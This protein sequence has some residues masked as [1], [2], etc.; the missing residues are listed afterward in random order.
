MKLIYIALFLGLTGLYFVNAALKIDI[1]NWENLIHSGIR[2][3][4]GFIILGAGHF[5]SH[6]P[7]LKI[8]LALVFALILADDILDYFRHVDSFTPEFILH[9][10]YMLFW[11]SVTGYLTLRAV[12]KAAREEI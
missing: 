7:E 5:Y 10:F 9:G 12:K 3:F 11:G 8:S 4:S 2:F 6:K 1:F